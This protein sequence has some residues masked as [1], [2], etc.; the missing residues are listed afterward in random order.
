MRIKKKKFF[1]M[2]IPDRELSREERQNFS[3]DDFKGLG[4]ETRFW[5]WYFQAIWSI[6]RIFIVLYF[7]GAA[8]SYGISLL[9]G[10]AFDYMSLAE[11][12]LRLMI[13]TPFLPVIMLVVA[14]LWWY[15]SIA[16]Y[17]I[18]GRSRQS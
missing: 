3:E 8:I 12:F 15:G 11:K 17:R 4:I 9:S 14:N 1:G 7:F 2:P 16:V 10:E 13:L 6:A 18:R 5:P